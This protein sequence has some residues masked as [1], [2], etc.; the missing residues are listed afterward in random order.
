MVYDPPVPEVIIITGA[1]N[2]GKSTYL[3]Q[4][5][6]RERAAGHSI[7]GV[8]AHGIFADGQKIGYDVED[9]AGGR[10]LPL[11]RIGQQQEGDQKVGRYW[12]SRS[13]LAMARAALLSFAPGG[14]VFL[15]EVGPLEL[16]GEGYADCISTLLASPISRLYVV[17]RAGLVAQIAE[18][19]LPGCSVRI[20][21]APGAGDAGPT[22]RT[23]PDGRRMT[24]EP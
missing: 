1:I 10:T 3:R 2:S 12:L 9:I 7:S 8:I 14:V 19:F 15:D 23:H 20:T 13:A 16:S 6:A 22:A 5:V 21:A 17:V 18:R 11:T 24:S 4:L